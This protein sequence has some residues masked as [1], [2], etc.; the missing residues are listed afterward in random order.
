LAPSYLYVLQFNAGAFTNPKA[1]QDQQIT[2]LQ[3]VIPW[4]DS[5]D[6]IERYAWFMAEPNF[7]GGSTTNKDGKPTKLGQ[8]YA[9]S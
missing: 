5:T 4:M 3:N 6:Y 7:D 8:Y 2:F 1:T 9:F